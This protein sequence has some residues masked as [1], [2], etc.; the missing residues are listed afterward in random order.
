[1]FDRMADRLGLRIQ[2]L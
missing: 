1:V 2:T